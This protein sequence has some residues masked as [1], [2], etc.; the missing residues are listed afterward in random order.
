MVMAVGWLNPK[1]DAPAKFTEAT[2]RTCNS[3]HWSV[4]G[5]TGVKAGEAL[6]WDGAKLDGRALAVLRIQGRDSK[7]PP[8]SRVDF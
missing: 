8:T 1:P 7:Q 4:H 5:L 3:G 6:D 2:S